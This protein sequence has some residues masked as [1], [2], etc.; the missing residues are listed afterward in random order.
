MIHMFE[1]KFRTTAYVAAGLLVVCALMAA[2]F[3]AGKRW[4]RSQPVATTGMVLASSRGAIQFPLRIAAGPRHLSDASGA[5]FLIQGDAAWSLIAD[6]TREEVDV[7]L[8]DRAARGFN[9]I[10]V[11]LLEHRFA[12]HA[13]ANVYGAAPFLKP[14]DFSQPVDAYFSH[15][16][17]VIARARE[18][19]FLV[20]L[21]PAYLGANG[22]EDGWWTAMQTAGAE[23][24]QAY[25]RYLG[26]RFG[27]FD[28][29]LWVDGGD[30]DPPDRALVSAV[31]RGIREEAPQQMHTVHIHP[32]TS[33]IDF[34]HGD[35]DWIDIV[36]AYTYK[37]VCASVVEAYQ[38][39]PTRPVFLIESFYEHE[40]GTDAWR[41]RTQAYEAL[42][43]GAS[44]QVFG[45]NPI[46][47]F[48]DRGNNP[49]PGD[50][51]Q[52]LG[53]E[54]AL[55]QTHLANI[56]RDL[57]WWQ[58]EPDTGSRL[59]VDSGQADSPAVAAKSGDGTLALVYM[60]SARPIRLDLSQMVQPIEARWYDPASSAFTNVAITPPGGA[61]PLT[62]EPP[63]R[64]S[65]GESDWLL[66][67][68]TR[69]SGAQ[70]SAPAVRADP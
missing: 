1:A 6:V 58:L 55:S 46:W 64:K 12:R 59:L 39:A 65:T 67:L 62:L 3:V 28:N 48:R 68:R 40:F 44:G 63:P 50:W 27:K 66:V 41:T 54:G 37:H 56:F 9:T 70:S 61:G 22:G 36:T 53:S 29:I 32:E 51:W 47:H 57:P 15:A 49:A 14:G 35:D 43:C 19:G 26:R 23:R 38:A 30:F 60:R 8:S 52:N 45:N 21:A 18:K 17:W 11:N 25:G 24:L 16:E 42:L 20:L 69:S 4:Q 10:L 13:P 5:P 34:W 33:V 7:Y 31:A 2:T